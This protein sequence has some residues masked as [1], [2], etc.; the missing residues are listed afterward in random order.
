MKYHHTMNKK[1]IISILVMIGIGII[2]PTSYAMENMSQSFTDFCDK[3][4]NDT[5]TSA[6]DFICEVDILQMFSDIESLKEESYT[7]EYVSGYD[8]T[9]LD[10]TCLDGSPPR[11]IFTANMFGY[12]IG[13]GNELTDE[14]GNYIGYHYNLERI[15][16]YKGL[17][18]VQFE[19]VC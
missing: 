9:H 17:S 11:Q 8:I 1:I 18:L 13:S 19:I 2:V 3:K 12:E 15:P 5:N 7:V 6:A 16:N 4:L 10:A 14:S